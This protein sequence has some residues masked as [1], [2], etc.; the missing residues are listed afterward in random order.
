MVFRLEMLAGNFIA[1]SMAF[2][3]MAKCQVIRPSEEVMMPSTL[4]LV[5]LL[6]NGKEDTANNFARGHYTIDK[7]IV[8]LCLDR[9]KKLT[10]NCTGLQ[11]F[12]V[13]NAMGGS[14]G[15]DLGSQLLERLSVDYAEKVY[16]M[17]L[18]V[19]EITNIAF[20]PSS[21]MAKCDPSHGKYKAC[22]LKY[23]GD[24]VPKD[25]NAAVAT[26]KTKR[27]TQFVD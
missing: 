14:T 24:V 8:D 16:Y 13:F 20:E 9:I 1:S 22:C 15:F 3:L 4:S 21:M 19:A 12:V 11:G 17:Q 2:S 27:T 26:I 18:S 6:I 23:R 10:D 5:K 7:E 25:V